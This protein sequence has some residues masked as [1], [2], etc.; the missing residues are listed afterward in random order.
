MARGASPE[1]T[2]PG[3]ERTCVGCGQRRPVA[4][5]VRIRYGPGGLRV[6][7]ERRGEGRGA[8]LCPDPRCLENTV[9]L[10]ALRRA[11][12]SDVVPVNARDLREAINQAVLQKVERLLGLAR[13]ARKIVVG[14]RAIR[15]A[16]G[17]GWVRLVLVRRHD[18]DS[19]SGVN[20]QTQE[21]AERRGVPVMTVFS[22]D[23]PDVVFGD[24]PREAVA[25]LDDGF[26]E[27][28]MRTLRYWIR[29]ENGGRPG[30]KVLGRRTGGGTRE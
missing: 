25:L 29:G 24:Q 8:Y 7:L 27:G 4:E 30:R 17:A 21:E 19:V 10:K 5:L 26:A 16:L 12:G 9:K 1:T 11:L 14:S 3:P 6:H 23:A 15:Q 18:N 28:I 2:P 13:R 22:G 20:R